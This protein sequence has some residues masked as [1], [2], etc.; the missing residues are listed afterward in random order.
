M[1]KQTQAF[2]AIL[3]LAFIIQAGLGAGIS[4]IYRGGKK[5]PTLDNHCYFDEHKLTIAVN[6][7]I[8]PTNLEN[9][10]VRVRCREDYVLELKYCPKYNPSIPCD[11]SPNDYSKPYPDCCPVITCNGRVSPVE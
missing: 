2:L 8:F 9:T 3:A 6:E 1:F 10:C 11:I 4:F 5:H 7:T